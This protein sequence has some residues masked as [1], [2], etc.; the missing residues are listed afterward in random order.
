MDEKQVKKIQHWK[1][2][3]SYLLLLKMGEGAMI[4]GIW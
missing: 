1:D 4:Q 3:T 2:L